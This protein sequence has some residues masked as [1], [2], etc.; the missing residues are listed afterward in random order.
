MNAGTAPGPHPST[1]ARDRCDREVL[2]SE[3]NKGT[4]EPALPAGERGLT[5]SEP[6]G[7]A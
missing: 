2:V 5:Q 4:G 6:A 7:V 1:R 3:T